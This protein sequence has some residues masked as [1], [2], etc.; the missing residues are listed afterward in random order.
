[1][2]NIAQHLYQLNTILAI[3][4]LN[5]TIHPKIVTSVAKLQG[6]TYLCEPPSLW[7]GTLEAFLTIKRTIHL[8][9]LLYEKVHLSLAA[10]VF[11]SF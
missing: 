11:Q 6:M 1:M 9:T 3:P 2:L 7:L 8:S 4:S 10:F 5:F